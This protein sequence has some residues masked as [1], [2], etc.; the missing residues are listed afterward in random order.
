MASG[1]EDYSTHVV[2]LMVPRYPFSKTLLAVPVFA[3][4]SERLNAFLHNFGK[5]LSVVVD[6]EIV[7]GWTTS[8]LES[9][10]LEFGKCPGTVDLRPAEGAERRGASL[11]LGVR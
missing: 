6:L 10:S 1:A 8:A 4:F 2:G 5:S 11:P 7:G 9:R 3:R